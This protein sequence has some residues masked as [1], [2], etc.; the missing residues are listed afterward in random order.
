M[1]QTRLFI[2]CADPSLRLALLLYLDRAPQVRVTGFTD[3]LEKLLPQ[4]ESVHPDVLL[5]EWALPLPELADLFG[6]IHQLEPRPSIVYLSGNTRERAAVIKAGADE[7][8]ATN[9]PPDALIQF[10]E[11]HRQKRP[12]QV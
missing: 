10:I 11:N 2:A 8:I 7:V 5:L 6:Q 12:V 9:A 1:P 4:L 3:L